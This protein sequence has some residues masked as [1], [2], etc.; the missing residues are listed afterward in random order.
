VAAAKLQQRKSI[1]CSA[2]S[3]AGPAFK[4]P[5]PAPSSPNLTMNEEVSTG[6]DSDY[7]K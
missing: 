4:S 7:T 1:H 3:L 5:S 6:S 2:R